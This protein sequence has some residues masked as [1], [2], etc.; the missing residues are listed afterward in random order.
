MKAPGGLQNRTEADLAALAARQ[1]GVFHRRQALDLG[2]SAKAIRVRLEGGRWQTLHPAV[3]RSAGAPGTWPQ[4]LMAAWLAAGPAAAASHRSA[5]TLWGL[6]GMEPGPIDVTVPGLGK[7]L[8][9]G[10]K[11]HRTRTLTRADV[12]EQ[13]GIPVTRPARTLLDL[14]SVLDRMAL[15]AALD[16]ALRDGHV[17]AGHLLRRLDAIGSRGRS[18]TAVL[19]ELLHDRRHGRPHESAREAALAAML[20]R[21]GSPPMVRQYELRAA[22]GVLVARFDLADPVARVAVEFDSYRHHFG[23]QAW[24]RD[25]GRHNRATALGWLVFHATEDD[26]RG[27][28]RDALCQAVGEARIRG[29]GRGW[30]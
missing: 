1:H 27:P 3:Y 2:F 13:A 20:D 16:S 29:E 14:A 11:V 12:G 4:R 7:R 6:D 26:L 8:V 23:R 19:Q 9:T 18:G 17:S 24:R 28:A 21:A 5:G 15:E 22:D 10:A 30:R 25:Q